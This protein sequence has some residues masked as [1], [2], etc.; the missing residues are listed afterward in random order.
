M[1]TRAGSP[2]LSWLRWNVRIGSPAGAPHRK[3]RSG[4]A[5]GDHVG[6]RLEGLA[7]RAV[8]EY[9]ERALAVSLRDPTVAKTDVTPSGG[10]TILSREDLR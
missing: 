4:R 10:R 5:G 2:Y 1:S 7:D 8:G 9:G 3:R 6:E